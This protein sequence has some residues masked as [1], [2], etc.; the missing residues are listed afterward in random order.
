MQIPSCRVVP[1]YPAGNA[2]RRERNLTN[3]LDMTTL[4]LRELEVYSPLPE[5]KLSENL[6][7]KTLAFE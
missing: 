1:V 3:P 2:V 4:E 6:W 7:D 5:A